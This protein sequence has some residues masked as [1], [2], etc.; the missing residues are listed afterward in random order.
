MTPY[1]VAAY[2]FPQYHTDPLND[3]W[4][5]QEWTEWEVLKVARPRFP[6][7]RQ[8][9]VPAWGY[10]DEADPAWAAREIDLAADHG[11]T[12]FLYDWY[13]YKGRPF[14]QDALE[15]GFLQAANKGRLKFALMWANH[16]WVNLYPVRFT[17]KPEML[18]SGRISRAA[19]ERL[20]DYVISHYFIQPNYLTLAG[21]PY[22]SIYDLGN[23][24]AGLGGVEATADVLRRFR[25]KVRAAGFP[26]LHLNAIAWGVQGLPGEK[27]LADPAQVIAELGFASV[28]SYAWIHH[29]DFNGAGFPTL[30][31]QHAAEVNIQAWDEQARQYTVPFFPNVSMGWDSSPRTAQSDRYKPGAYPWLAVLTGNTP[32]AFGKALQ[33]AKAFLDQKGHQPGLVTINAWNEWTEGSYLLP[34]TVHGTAYLEAVRAVFGALVPSDVSI[35]D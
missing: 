33:R 35:P 24:I 16:D 9:I 7:H 28:G 17:N 25:G 5:G 6:G 14:L 32:S 1:E 22:F 20:T 34:D 10:F 3:R 29:H 23:L 8:P 27:P 18:A 26:D 19:F 11:I 13:W 31:Y 4:H 2:Y 15:R 12:A 30:D 21:A